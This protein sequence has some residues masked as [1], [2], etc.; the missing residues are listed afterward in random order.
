MSTYMIVIIW[1]I[2]DS[3]GIMR[4]SWRAECLVERKGNN[5]WVVTEYEEEKEVNIGNNCMR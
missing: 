2:T 3:E 4:M 1:M 5:E